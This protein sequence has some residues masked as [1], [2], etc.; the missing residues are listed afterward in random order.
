MFFILNY[1]ENL[2]NTLCVSCKTK[3]ENNSNNFKTKEKFINHEKLFPGAN[4]KGENP[5]FLNFANNFQLPLEIQKIPSLLDNIEKK[6]TEETPLYE[7][8][9]KKD[10]SSSKDNKYTENK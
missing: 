1:V 4:V 5:Y 8:D 6:N 7:Y 3:L 2:K 9:T 10:K